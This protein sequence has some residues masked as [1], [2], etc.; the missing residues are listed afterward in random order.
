MEPI[1]EEMLMA[2]PEGIAHRLRL[3]YTR[4]NFLLNPLRIAEYHGITVKAADFH[5]GDIKGIIKKDDSCIFLND[6]DS[7][8]QKRFSLAHEL[9]HYFLHFPQSDAFI[10]TQAFFE[11]NGIHDLNDDEKVRA[12][13]E[14]YA[15]RFAMAL[16][17]PFDEV[18]REWHLA[19]TI[20]HMADRFGVPVQIVSHRVCEMRNLGFSL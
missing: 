11:V 14:L 15:N 8:N 16:L 5:K 9:G 7:L 3:T 13:V 6:R 19:D 1:I 12:I 17:L 10:C 4:S 2:N 18:Y 20:E